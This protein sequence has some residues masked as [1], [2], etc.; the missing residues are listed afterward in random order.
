MTPAHGNVVGQKSKTR[1]G[2]QQVVDMLLPMPKGV[3]QVYTSLSLHTR[4]D[5]LVFSSEMSPTQN[6]I[7][8]LC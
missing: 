3:E 1:V 4:V 5:N 6:N 8:K 7:N 2:G